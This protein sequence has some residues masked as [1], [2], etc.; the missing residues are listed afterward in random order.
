MNA[1][2]RRGTRPC[3]KSC[4]NRPGR[5]LRNFDLDCKAVSQKTSALVYALYPRGDGEP[6][7]VWEWKFPCDPNDP[8]TIAKLAE[9][10]EPLSRGE[11]KA[12]LDRAGLGKSVPAARA[13]AAVPAQAEEELWEFNEL[14]LL[15]G[16]RR[17]HEEIRSRGESPELLAALCV[18]YANLGSVTEYH[19]SAAH[20]AYS[21]RALVYAER[22]LRNNKKSSWGLWHR[23]YARALVGLHQLALADVLSAKELREASA[24][25]LPLPFW[26]G[27]LES[28]CQGRL[29]QM[30]KEATSPKQARLAAYLNLVAVLYSQRADWIVSAASEVIEKAP[31]CLRGW[32][33]PRRNSA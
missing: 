11:L 8:E 14:G 18:G 5:N 10:I 33:A 31:G 32:D 29:P 22:L 16:L 19:L 30:V 2:C 7:A 27:A 4:R 23:A 13:A 12:V 24:G 28:F 3:G 17:I 1:V 6:K 25:S 26:T 15:D 9:Q 21:A 20:K